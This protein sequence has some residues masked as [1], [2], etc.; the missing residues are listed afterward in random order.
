MKLIYQTA[1]DM[2]TIK[3]YQGPN[4][5]FHLR[6]N[7]GTEIHSIYDPDNL[8]LKPELDHY[9][10]FFNVFPLLHG[11]T[12][13]ILVLGVGGGTALRQLSELFPDIELHGVEIDKA[14]IDVAQKY[15]NLTSPNVHI[16]IGDAMQYLKTTEEKFDLIFLDAF[17][18]GNLAIRF[19]NAHV[20]E[21]LKK[22]L[23]PGGMVIANYLDFRT[24]TYLLKRAMKNTFK[25]VYKY[26]IDNT[27]NCM[28]YGSDENYPGI[29]EE[30]PEEL[31]VLANYF[32]E[33]IKRM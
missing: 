28:M 18:G 8:I 32:N 33:R 11:K 31:T 21:D 5:K 16:H 17:I 7:E 23:N 24:V 2:N 26:N 29:T 12:K 3:V 10:N 22:S 9:W 27:Y 15:F 14:I 19:L 25:K 1:S 20:F 13:R 4:G 30:P 6:L